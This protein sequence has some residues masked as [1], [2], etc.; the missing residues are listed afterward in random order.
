MTTN[1][2]TN[3]GTSGTSGSDTKA[4]TPKTNDLANRDTFLKLFIAQ[5]KNQNPLNPTDGVQFMTQLA[6]FSSLEQ[7]VQMSQDLGAIRKLLEAQAAPA[8]SDTTDGTK[9]KGA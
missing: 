2:V 5:I 7:N 8:T 4:P 9:T 1:G 6:Q 3:N